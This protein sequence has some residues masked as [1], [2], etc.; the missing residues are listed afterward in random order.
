[1][2][3]YPA[4]IELDENGSDYNVIFPDLDGCYTPV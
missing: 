2:I 3:T 1:M 4:I